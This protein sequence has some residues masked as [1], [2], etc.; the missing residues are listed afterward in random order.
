[1]RNPRK[2]HLFSGEVQERRGP[3]ASYAL[4]LDFTKRHPWISSGLEGPPVPDHRKK[5]LQQHWSEEIT[6]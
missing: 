5:R 6:I 1:M 2:Y 4:P 3:A